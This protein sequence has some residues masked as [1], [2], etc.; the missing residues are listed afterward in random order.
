LILIA[1]TL[2]EKEVLDRQ[3]FLRLFENSAPALAATTGSAD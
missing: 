3:E 1:E 2:L